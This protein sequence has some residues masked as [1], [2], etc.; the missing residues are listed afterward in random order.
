MSTD[1]K[2]KKG[3]AKYFDHDKNMTHLYPEDGRKH[4]LDNCWCKPVV[5]KRTMITH[6]NKS[7]K[8]NARCGR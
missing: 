1:F 4:L 8:N 3:Y 7:K 2:I 5:D 6:H